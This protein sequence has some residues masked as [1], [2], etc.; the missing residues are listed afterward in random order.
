M[1]VA[2]LNAGRGWHTDELQRAAAQRGHR[3][4]LLPIQAL[5]AR[6]GGSPRLA[7]AGTPLEG[8]DAVP[9]RIVPR[10]PEQTVFR[11]TPFIAS[12]DWACRS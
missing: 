10:G 11:L 6:V 1:N 7:A 8:C 9:L 4:C 5:T 3:T 12:S 2:I